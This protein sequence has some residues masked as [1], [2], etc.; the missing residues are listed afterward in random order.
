MNAALAKNKPCAKDLKM[1]VV[2]EIESRCPRP[3]IIEKLLVRVQKRE[4]EEIKEAIE[5]HKKTR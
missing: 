3:P 5:E 4:R 1:L 2:L